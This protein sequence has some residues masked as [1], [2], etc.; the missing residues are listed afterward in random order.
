MLRVLGGVLIFAGG[1]LG[2][3]ACGRQRQR[4][5][6]TLSD[7]LTALRRMGEEIRSARTP[8]PVLLERLAG[9]CGEDAGAFLRAVSAAARRGE[10]LAE[11]WR[12]EAE[13]LP[14][15]AED[16]GMLSSLG[17]DLRGD[18]ES[19][20]KAISL[21][22]FQLAKR[23]EESIRRKPEED[24]RGTALCLSAAALLVI[25]LL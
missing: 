5:L 11:A 4:R 10:P 7:L 22:T 14:L 12:N 2:K 1:F 8:M 20:C 25:L 17:E 15:A 3:L 16:R 13:A 9:F 19:I 24:K 6:D 23:L 21:V 18:E